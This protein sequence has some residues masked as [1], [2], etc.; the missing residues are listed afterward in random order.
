MKLAKYVRKLKEIGYI[1]NED[2]NINNTEK[3]N[4]SGTVYQYTHNKNKKSY[5]LICKNKIYTNIGKKGMKNSENKILNEI[6]YTGTLDAYID[7]VLFYLNETLYI[8]KNKELVK[9]KY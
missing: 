9:I 7:N 8:T 1:K 5:C 4:L 3:I 6:E 2:F